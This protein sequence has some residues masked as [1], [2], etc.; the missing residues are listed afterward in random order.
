M[1]ASF[2]TAVKSF[3]TKVDG[4]TDV[5]AADINDLQDEIAAIETELGVNPKW[6]NSICEGRLTLTS[7]TAVTTADVT[8]AT[9]VYFA[10]YKG[11]RIAL[12]DGTRWK[13]HAFTERS[14]S[15][16]GFT[17]GR[18][19]DVFLYDNAG[20]LTL[21][22]V[23]WTN[24]TTRATALA[25][26]DGAYVQTGNTSRR[27]L[28]TIRITATTGQCE[29]SQAKRYV[30]NY[31]NRVVR[32]GAKTEATSH[33]HT[34]SW[35]YWNNDTAQKMEFVIGVAEDGLSASLSAEW[36]GNGTIAYV[37][38]GLDTTTGGVGSRMYFFGSQQAGSFFG[39]AP[40]LG[41]HYLAV[42]EYGNAATPTFTRHYA[43]LMIPG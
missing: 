6:P 5:M 2:P 16:S 17:A 21:Q 36:N 23:I 43:Y 35:R 18:N 32:L 3:A 14:L 31:A 8:A 30:W 7:G 39:F 19:Y 20:T 28:G 40:Q 41:Y 15:L 1:T 33:N 38:L 34:A 42:L 27:Y 29:D 12:Y 37:A 24:D 13:L 22:A 10:P 26:Q 4:V 25:T 9:T 11:N